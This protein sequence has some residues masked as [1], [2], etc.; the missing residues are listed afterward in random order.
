M[1]SFFLLPYA[2]VIFCQKNIGAKTGK[3]QYRRQCPDKKI[4]DSPFTIQS[5]KK[6]THL[7]SLKNRRHLPLPSYSEQLKSKYEIINN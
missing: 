3:S 4:V 5:E 6:S 2:F 7:K 1:R